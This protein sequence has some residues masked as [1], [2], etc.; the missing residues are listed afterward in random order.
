MLRL[1][2]NQ[3]N[4]MYEFITVISSGYSRLKRKLLIMKL[5][6][7]LLMSC[8]LQVSA[9]GFAQNKITI[10]ERNAS[11]RRILK[12]IS[13]QSGYD[14][15]F[16]ADAVKLAK[17][18]DID[19]KKVNLDEALKSVFNNQPLMA[20][21]VEGQSVIVKD[22]KAVI[23][24][25]NGFAQSAAVDVTGTVLDETGQGLPGATVKLKG[26]N[27][28]TVTD[29]NGKFVLKE[30]DDSATLVISFLGYLT[31]ELNVNRRNQVT[32]NLQ[33]DLGKLNEVVVVGYGTQ[34][35][36]NLT[37]AVAQI[38]AR[39]LVKAPMVNVAQMLAGKLPGLTTVETSG[40]PGTG[41]VSMQVRGI[42][43]FNDAGG[44]R[45]LFLVDG[46][47]RDF[48]NIDPNDV[49]T[50][51]I[52]K[53]AAAGAVYGVKAGQGV[54]MI[55]TKRGKLSDGKPNVTYSGA[56]SLSQSTRFPEFLNGTEFVEWFSKAQEMDGTVRTFSDA[57]KAK[58]TDGDLSDGIENTNWMDFA[59]RDVAPTQQHNVSIT[60]GSSNARYFVGAGFLDQDGIVTGNNFKRGNIRSNIDI[61]I[62]KRL[63]M[64]F[65]L[66]G[67]KEDG[68]IQGAADFGRQDNNNVLYQAMV[69]Y[70]FV[71]T[72]YGGLPTGA[73]AGTYNTQAYLEKSGFRKTSN[74]IL[75][76]SAAV[77]Y[78]IP[79]IK[80]LQ[81][82]MF[83]SYD[84]KYFGTRIFG[85]AFN[86]N[87]YNVPTVST[88]FGSWAQTA[89]FGLVAGGNYSDGDQK[90]SRAVLRPSLEYANTFGKH[91]VSG[92]LLYE[93]TEDNIRLLSGTKR[94]FA[95]NDIIELNMG[96]TYVA[97]AQ[98]TSSASANAGL[99]GRINYAYDSRY[100]FEFV[101]RRDGSY[102]FPAAQR[103][104]TFPSVS[105]GWVVSNEEFFKKLNSKIDLF[106]VKA[107]AGLLG[108]DNVNDF[109]YETY[110]KY[111][112]TTPSVVFGNTPY[113][114][115]GTS[116]SY[117]S[118]N[119]TW[120]KTK[121]Y[122]V[123]FELSAWNGLLGV[124]FDAFYK[125]T[126]DILQNVGGAYPTSL[127][128]YYPSIENT[129]S[130]D[131]R[132]FELT[133]THRKTV[134]DFTYNISGNIAYA[135][136]KILSK[137][138]TEG[139]PAYQS[140]IGKSTGI[141]L[142][143]VA[144]GLIQSQEQLNNYP[145]Q[146]SSRWVGDI[147]SVDLN[148]DGQINIQD[149]TY[150]G[151]QNTPP[152]YFGLS[153]NLNYKNFDFS[154]VWQGAA[155]NDILLG[156][157]Y[158]NGAEDNTLATKAFYASR[159]SAKYVVEN[160]WTPENT[161][162]RYPRLSLAHATSNGNASTW[163]IEN[164]AYLR[165]KS[166]T[167]G[168]NLPALKKTLGV[169]NIRLYLA[170]T[171]LLTFSALDYFDPETPSVTNAYYPQQKTYSLGLNV[172]F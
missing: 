138:E 137:I 9:A 95:V 2:K 43:T 8:L 147:A 157:T 97:A 32:V 108:R 90:I 80:G 163:W 68:S 12:E 155:L 160:S 123:G 38:S 33:L 22:K 106:K 63:S 7:L 75:E 44:A 112:A 20:Y 18:V 142:G 88:P 96:Q 46:V 131:V 141:P 49:E 161:N 166:L 89:Y 164:G 42:G 36:V 47:E 154:M 78:Q 153:G 100:L 86:V 51:T 82:K 72:T 13:R 114:A 11:L 113:Y 56:V 156:G 122:N 69:A 120:E 115:L 145:F 111:L 62:S 59:L 94:T 127:G 4:Q 109:L 152:L 35:K 104:G 102:K 53:D 118:K 124:E 21:T 24:P 70:P 149:R 50:V 73:G 170:G 98:G 134:N 125:Y 135:K 121:S 81:A 136:N 101:M 93:S 66:A 84:W 39:E 6:L 99:V 28:G 37:G 146:A 168:Y 79:G 27:T 16:V 83:M 54:I 150:I 169:Q 17:P 167:F 159:N 40:Q 165:L 71:T 116:N 55:T 87:K 91:E 119:L 26:T 60:G 65:N 158:D 67:R 92:L 162:T 76:S 14:L 52:L 107:S 34:K 58:I 30:I 110:Y 132:G 57:F 117:P 15:I 144:S 61:N 3:T 29:K 19:V 77:K 140:M 23:I 148:N 130:V 25:T 64:E 74:M 1:N 103:W 31:Q 139:I 172:T 126:Y 45:P 128:G 171:N 48:G 41:N 85:T 105:A 129:G 143:Y 151:R 133:L 10:T 5:T